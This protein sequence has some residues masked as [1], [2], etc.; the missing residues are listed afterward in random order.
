MVEIFKTNV[1]RKGEAKMLLLILA[2]YF[3]N[4]KI[5]FDLDGCD[6]ILRVEGKSIIPESVVELII[7]NDYECVIL[8]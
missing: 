2:E 4:H 1:Q 8:A 3:P 5:N 7:A 6:K